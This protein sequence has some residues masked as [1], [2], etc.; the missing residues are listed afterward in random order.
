MMEDM[1][2]FG[3]NEEQRRERSSFVMAMS[4]HL[5]LLGQNYLLTLNP[6]VYIILM[7]C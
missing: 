3:S 1:G 2:H 4:G 7:R 5:V 6:Y